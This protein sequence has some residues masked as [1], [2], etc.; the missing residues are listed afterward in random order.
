MRTRLPSRSTVTES[1][2]SSTSLSR[3]LTKMTLEPSSATLRIMA[4][5]CAASLCDSDAVGS[6]R[7]NR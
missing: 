7:M 2:S 6:S 1:Q 4:V 3:W 5:T